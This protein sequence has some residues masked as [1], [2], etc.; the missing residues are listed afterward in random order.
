ML[1]LETLG[2]KPSAPIL[3]IGAVLFNPHSGELGEQF[4]TAPPTPANAA[5]WEMRYWNSGYNIWGEWER[6]TAEQHAEMSVQHAADN[7]YEFRVLYDVPPAQQSTNAADWGIN[8]QT[9]TPIL[10]YKNC[11][12]IESEQAH[13][14][15]SLI[16]GAATPAPAVPPEAT[17]ENIEN[18]LA[19][20]TLFFTAGS[21]S[22]GGS[23]MFAEVWNACRAAMLA[24]PVSDGYKLPDGFKLMPLEMTDEIG[25]AIA[26][27]AR[28]CGGIAL[29]IY[30]AALAA[31]PEG[32]NVIQ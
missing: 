7:D 29:C 16:N 2:K 13:Y 1:G 27:E 21:L 12:V 25:E 6:I 5:A 15:L 8:K 4:Y 23:V 19:D 31:A 18:L 10:F 9:G 22:H 26:M 17:P 20:I 24:Q 28:C 30:E 3:T 32:G 11:S 14:V